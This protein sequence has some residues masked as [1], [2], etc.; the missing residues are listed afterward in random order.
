MEYV[1]ALVDSP[2]YQD[3]FGDA[4]DSNDGEVEEKPLP[5]TAE[6]KRPAVTLPAFTAGGNI[7]GSKHDR[8][9]EYKR[10]FGLAEHVLRGH[11]LE[12]KALKGLAGSNKPNF[13][14]SCDRAL[15]SA[16]LAAGN[17]TSRVDIPDGAGF[18]IIKVAD[19]YYV[20]RPKKAQIV[21]KKLGDLKTAFGITEV[22]AI[23]GAAATAAYYGCKEME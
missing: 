13:C 9:R 18:G 21:F 12:E 23:T 1:N 5:A 19:K 22:Q 20:V 8:L 7:A 10:L 15:I 4:G 2:A 6:A 16:V 11:F 14:W 17:R 3:R